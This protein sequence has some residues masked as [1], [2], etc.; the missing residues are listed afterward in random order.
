MPVSIWQGSLDV[1]VPQSNGRIFA[2]NIPQA[3]AHFIEGEGHISLVYNHGEAILADL[4][5]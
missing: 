2:N 1:N 4:L 3:T 5:A